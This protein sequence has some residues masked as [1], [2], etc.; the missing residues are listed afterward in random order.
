M[1][2]VT[3]SVIY[4]RVVQALERVSERAARPRSRPDADLL[5]R[6]PRPGDKRSEIGPT[7]LIGQARP[8]FRHGHLMRFNPWVRA[9]HLERAEAVG[10]A[11]AEGKDRRA[12]QVHASRRRWGWGRRLNDDRRLCLERP[13]I[14]ITESLEGGARAADSTRWPERRGRAAELVADPCTVGRRL[15]LGWRVAADQDH[16]DD[17][18]PT[19]SPH[20]C[21]SILPTG[22]SSLAPA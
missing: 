8:D 14:G 22:R 11:L 21:L 5:N 2:R 12:Y 19:E 4:G 1:V 16:A 10:R 7:D 3:S 9:S 6:N 13:E 17:G 15:S 18:E 20:G